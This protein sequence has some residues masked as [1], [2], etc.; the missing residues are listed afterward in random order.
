VEQLGAGRPLVAEGLGLGV[1]PVL[2]GRFEAEPLDL[3]RLSPA[4][5]GPVTGPAAMVADGALGD[6]QDAGGLGRRLA[7][8]A[9]DLDRHELLPRE[10]GQGVAPSGGPGDPV[11]A[12]DAL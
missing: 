6:A 11:P 1:P 4:V 5:G 8:L 10:L 9:Q 12:W 3:E 7:S 2:D